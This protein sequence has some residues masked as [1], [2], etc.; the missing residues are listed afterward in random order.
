MSE[1]VSVSVDPNNVESRERGGEN[2]IN[3][4][5]GIDPQKKTSYMICGVLFVLAV[6]IMGMAG[7][8]RGENHGKKQS[9]KVL[10]SKSDS[11]FLLRSM[12]DLTLHWQGDYGFTG[13]RSGD[14]ALYREEGGDDDGRYHLRVPIAA[15]NDGEEL[16]YVAQITQGAGESQM[17]LDPGR[18]LEQQLIRFE[19]RAPRHTGMSSGTAPVEPLGSL[20]MSALNTDFRAGAFDRAVETGLCTVES[21][22][23]SY[24]GS[25]VAR[26]PITYIEGE[27]STSVDAEPAA[28]YLV[29][30][31]GLIGAGVSSLMT[32]L[33]S[34]RGT[35]T[36]DAVDAIGHDARGYGRSSENRH[37]CTSSPYDATIS[38]AVSLSS[39]PSRLAS[40]TPSTDA[41]TLGVRTSLVRL[42]Q[43]TRKGTESFVAHHPMSGMN[44]QLFR[45]ES[46]AIGS[47]RKV[48]FS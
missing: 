15:V 42:T 20:I 16:L 25:L 19:W 1:Y 40:V 44:N 21:I 14:L 29:D 7:P 35:T 30:T 18:V 24:G 37:L 47:P 10:G 27:G 45:N 46:A 34:G 9:V 33:S 11:S 2:V 8:I 36:V 3:S 23:R 41:I 6:V 17:Y 13:P 22:C 4:I 12:D 32:A 26:L 39:L 28:F 43:L 5:A 48:C 31:S 38:S